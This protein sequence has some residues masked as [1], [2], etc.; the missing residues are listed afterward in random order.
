MSAY[1][2]LMKQAVEETL[3]L[4]HVTLYDIVIDIMHVMH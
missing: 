1:G 3:Y 4:K 2:I